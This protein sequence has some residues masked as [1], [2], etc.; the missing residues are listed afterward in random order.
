MKFG[1]SIHDIPRM[2]SCCVPKIPRHVLTQPDSIFDYD[3]F[4]IICLIHFIF[5]GQA[6]AYIFYI[7]VAGIPL[8][9]VWFVNGLT[10]WEILGICQMIV[11]VN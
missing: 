6:A 10:L 1:V 11:I 2:R 5:E 9:I 3:S 4:H 8:L 7:C